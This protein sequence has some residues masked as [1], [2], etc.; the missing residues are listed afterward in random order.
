MTSVAYRETIQV[1]TGSS[2][3]PSGKET[4]NTFA[5]GTCFD[6]FVVDAGTEAPCPDCA[7]EVVT[8]KLTGGRYSGS[9]S[10]YWT[11]TASTASTLTFTGTPAAIL[12]DVREV[13]RRATAEA[14]RRG[15]KGRNFMSSAE[16]AIER[17][18]ADKL[19][20]RKGN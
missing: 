14:A 18:V 17:R 13:A 19:A 9:H 10:A 3:P 5:C 2:D 16:I 12:L 1:E 8:I 4:M 7:A 6:T 11:A 20:N 15:L